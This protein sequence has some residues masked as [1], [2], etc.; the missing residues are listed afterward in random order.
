MPMIVAPLMG[1]NGWMLGGK[2]LPALHVQ[3]GGHNHTLFDAWQ[4]EQS[5]PG[6]A[7]E[8]GGVTQPIAAKAS[9]KPL[10]P[11]VPTSAMMVGAHAHCCTLQSWASA[12]A[13]G[14]SSAVFHVV[15]KGADAVRSAWPRT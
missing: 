14:G 9:A 13:R 1:G 11:P 6:G 5:W 7:H 3:A 10:V 8:G 2:P 15:C 4:V 12:L